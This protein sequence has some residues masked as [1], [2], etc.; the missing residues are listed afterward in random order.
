MDYAR[1]HRRHERFDDTLARTDECPR[2]RSSPRTERKSPAPR[3]LPGHR[4]LPPGQL[5]Q[6]PPAGVTYD[7]WMSRACGT[8][9]TLNSTSPDRLDVGVA[10]SLCAGSL[11]ALALHGFTGRPTCPKMTRCAGRGGN[12]ILRA[13]CWRGAQ[14]RF[15]A[16]DAGQPGL[17]GD[18]KCKIVDRTL[19]GWAR[20]W[21]SARRSRCMFTKHNAR[22]A[23]TPPP[24][25]S[26]PSWRC[27]ATRSTCSQAEQIEAGPGLQCRDSSPCLSSRCIRRCRVLLVDA[28]EGLLTVMRWSAA[29]TRRVILVLAGQ[30]LGRQ[31]ARPVHDLWFQAQRGP[32]LVQ[33]RPRSAPDLPTT[34]AAR[35]R[36]RAQLNDTQLYD[37]RP[38]RRS[39]SARDRPELDR[40]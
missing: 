25:C 15:D 2:P 6:I 38:S 36:F 1:R 21:N 10:V 27:A 28:P 16:R 40:L 9:A 7:Y 29:S 20:S 18:T 34:W 3:T 14:R 22:G 11:N 4:R 23:S 37:T 12:T 35:P 30:P 26:E 39:R 32:P 5:A 24:S 33:V 19:L 8:A 17:D 31:Q 13:T